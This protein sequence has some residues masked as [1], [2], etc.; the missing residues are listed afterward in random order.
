MILTHRECFLVFQWHDIIIEWNQTQIQISDVLEVSIATFFLLKNL[1]KTFDE[2][3]IKFFFAF[4]C[5]KKSFAIAYIFFW[6]YFL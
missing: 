2:K 5:N 6:F 1:S 3:K 4:E